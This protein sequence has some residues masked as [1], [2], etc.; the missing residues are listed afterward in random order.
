MNQLPLCP[1]VQQKKPI[2][3]EQIA[4]LEGCGNYTTVYLID[5]GRLLLSKNIGL[6]D[7]LLPTDAFVRLNKAYILSFSSL[8]DWKYSKPKSLTIRIPNGQWI[9][10]S[11][12]RIVEVKGKLTNL[13]H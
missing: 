13:Q 7:E 4:Y 8:T 3:I 12:R 5:G 6:F 9:E 2:F 10:V 11:R 1:R